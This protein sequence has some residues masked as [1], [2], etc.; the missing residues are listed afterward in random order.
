M[1]TNKWGYLK[2]P[3]QRIKVQKQLWEEL[4]RILESKGIRLERVGGVG[5]AGPY[6]ETLYKVL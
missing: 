5:E 6:G 2:N 4:L 3:K 1:T